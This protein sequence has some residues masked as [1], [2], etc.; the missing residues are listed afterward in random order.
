[1]IG[2]RRGTLKLVRGIPIACRGSDFRDSYEDLTNVGTRVEVGSNASFSQ[3]GHGECQIQGIVGL[4]QCRIHESSKFLSHIVSLQD[5]CYGVEEQLLIIAVVLV[6]RCCFLSGQELQ[7]HHPERKNIHLWR[8]HP[9]VDILGGQVS[10]SAHHM[11]CQLQEPFL[12]VA[13]PSSS[14][15]PEIGNLGSQVSI[16]KDV[17]A[18]EVLVDVRRVRKVVQVIQG[19]D[20]VVGNLYPLLPSQSSSRMRRIRGVELALEALVERATLGILVHKVGVSLVHAESREPDH[21][22]V[23]N[24]LQ[25]VYL[26]GDVPFHHLNS[27][28]VAL[29]SS[30]VDG[31]LNLVSL[32]EGIRRPPHLFYVIET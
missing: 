29:E 27:R 28:V 10:L 14:C 7:D 21:V 25:Y 17:A 23:I 12:D 32:A 20:D 9:V 18:L 22:G 5:S 31:A 3:L 8:Y 6:G 30:P 2:E 11:P 13:V 19:I 16:Q 26:G 15:Q 24:V 1:M 4:G